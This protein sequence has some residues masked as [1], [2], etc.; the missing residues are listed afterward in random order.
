MLTDI[1]KQ[2]LRRKL[3]EYEGRIE[4]MYKDTTGFVTVGVGHLLQDLKA[5]QALDFIHQASA[6]KATADE[7]KDDFEAILAAPAGL[8]A[9]L[10]KKYTKLRLTSTAIEELTNS[11]ID[12]FEKE[13]SRLYGHVEFLRFPS[14]VKLALFDMIFNLGMTKLRTGFPKFNR[15][16][17]ANDWA[18]AAKESNRLDI[19]PARNKYVKDLLIKAA[20]SARP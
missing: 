10:Y 14:E 7:I 17:K 8:F 11:H 6:K 5:A 12:S 13:L 15:S 20:Q 2:I 4:H 9:P 19:S 16:I 3:D 18:E 1:E